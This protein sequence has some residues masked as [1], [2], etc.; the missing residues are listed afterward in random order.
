MPKG[1][2]SLGTVWHNLTVAFRKKINFDNF[3]LVYEM[4]IYGMKEMTS[5]GVK[6]MASL[7]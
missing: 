2:T 5:L 3:S 7:V 4:D 6:E 1:Q